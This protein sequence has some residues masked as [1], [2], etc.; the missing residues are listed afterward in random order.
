MS[1]AILQRVL[2]SQRTPI[3]VVLTQPRIMKV[4]SGSSE[5]A[6]TYGLL[7]P[8]IQ[9]KTNCMHN[10]NNQRVWSIKLDETPQWKLPF[11]AQPYPCMIYAGRDVEIQLMA[12]IGQNLIASGCVF[13]ACTGE[14]CELWHDVI[15]E[16][17]VA[18]KANGSLDAEKTIMTS[19]HSADSL[20][21]VVFF[22]AHTTFDANQEDHPGFAEASRSNYLVLIIG[23]EPPEL[24]EKIAESLREYRNLR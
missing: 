13:V 11:A 6:S 16:E 19:W 1:I 8:H 17:V 9:L 15:D 5:N 10:E 14:A 3:V 20:E 12:E 24:I 7:L 2:R 22:F 21:E 4:Y 18:A 23:K